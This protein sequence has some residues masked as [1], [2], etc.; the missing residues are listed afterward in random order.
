MVK[1]AKQGGDAWSMKTDRELIVLSK[2]KT[3]ET[4]ADHFRRPPKSILDIPELTRSA[5]IKLNP[6]VSL[7]PAAEFLSSMQSCWIGRRD[8]DGH[9]YRCD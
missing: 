3:I 6:R 2:T 8:P 5:G 7:R 1:R 4:L 9:A